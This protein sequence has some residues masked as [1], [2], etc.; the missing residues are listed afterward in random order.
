MAKFNAKR[1]ME[2]FRCSLG[3]GFVLGQLAV[4]LEAVA[5]QA[6]GVTNPVAWII[7]PAVVGFATL[8]YT[9]ELH[10]SSR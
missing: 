1:D 4:L 6:M 9:T 2:V 7:I 8:W 10:H 5:F 3:T